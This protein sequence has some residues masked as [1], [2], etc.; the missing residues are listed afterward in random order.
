MGLHEVG[1]SGL[2]RP[3][4]SSRMPAPSLTLWGDCYA[5]AFGVPAGS[6]FEFLHFYARHK[7]LQENRFPLEY[8]ESHD[9]GFLLIVLYQTAVTRKV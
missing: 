5:P 1:G 9:P 6:K 2:T 3:Q 7:A 8:C 4:L